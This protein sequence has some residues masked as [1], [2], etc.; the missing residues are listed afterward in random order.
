MTNAPSIG[1]EVR[2]SRVISAPRE[3]VFRA[4][5]E[6]DML[7]RWYAPHG[8]T[9]ELVRMDVRVNGG[10]HHG[11]RGPAHTD[12]WIVGTFL[13]VVPPE[14]LVY[15]HTF[16]DESGRRLTPA[17][18]GREPDWPEEIVTTVTFD[19]L[20]GRTKVVIH[21]TVY[22]IFAKRTGAYPSWLQMLDRLEKGFGANPSAKTEDT[23]RHAC[24]DN[25]E[26]NK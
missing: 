23:K 4:W 13:E 2:L 14:R 19:D 7:Q 17:Q 18:A 11:I 16:S 12:C 20:C 21:Q 8:C 24:G 1:H 15:S 25:E 3:L 5:T 26:G 6:R 10:F 9:L 22:E